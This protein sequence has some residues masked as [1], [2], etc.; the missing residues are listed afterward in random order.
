MAEPTATDRA[1]AE[2]AR[3][4]GAEAESLEAEW[5]AIEREQAAAAGETP[6]EPD[7]ELDKTKTTPRDEAGRFQKREGEE[8][9]KPA[10]RGKEGASSVAE[11]AAFE[12]EARRQAKASV[13]Q[14]ESQLTER[15]QRLALREQA[16]EASV[17][18]RE[19]FE[20]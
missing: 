11:R 9:P 2:G 14:R 15:E 20:A 17:K 3:V 7:G 13:A 8:P 16:A 6:E 12:R 5:R 19:R 1:I 18:A 4:A 10:K